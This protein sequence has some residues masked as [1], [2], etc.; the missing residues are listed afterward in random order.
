M[1]KNPVSSDS[2]C[3]CV[4]TQERPVLLLNKENISCITGGCTRAK[5]PTSGL[6]NT[7]MAPAYMSTLQL[8]LFDSH[9]L[10]WIQSVLED[11]LFTISH[12]ICLTLKLQSS[13]ILRLQ[14]Q[15][16]CRKPSQS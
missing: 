9:S 11:G 10:S 16:Q 5:Q 7:G 4:M 8:F 12:S 1:F 2:W 6:V 15:A 13:L 3:L 14:C